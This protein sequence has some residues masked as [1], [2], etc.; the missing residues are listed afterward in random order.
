MTKVIWL[1]FF[2]N[3]FWFF[4]FFPSLLISW[5]SW[6]VIHSI[7][8]CSHAIFL[9][10]YHYFC[11]SHFALFGAYSSFFSSTVVFLFF[12]IFFMSFLFL[13]RCRSVGQLA[14]QWDGTTHLE[15]ESFIDIDNIKAKCFKSLAPFA[16]EFNMMDFFFLFCFAGETNWI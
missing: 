10:F 15:S 9:S 16:I 14:I 2:L 6:L 7:T 5:L 8:V 1:P 12:F 13:F 4:I 3:N 11:L